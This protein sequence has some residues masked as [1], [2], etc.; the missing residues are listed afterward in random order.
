MRE[1]I[2]IIKRCKYTKDNKLEEVYS[3][4]ILLVAYTYDGDGIITSTLDR[5][6]DLNQNL[7]INDHNY[8][9]SLTNN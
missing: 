7:N 6:L 4:N 5:D 8:I 1:L 2:Q 9:N 3:G